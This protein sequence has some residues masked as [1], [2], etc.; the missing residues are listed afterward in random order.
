MTETGETTD[1]CLICRSPTDPYFSKSYDG[2]PGSPF[3]QGL[4]V[5]YRR[6]GQ[7]GFV[8]SQTHRALTPAQW[9]QLNASWH[10]HFESGPE[11]RIVNQPPYAD[12]ALALRLL[13]ANGLVD[14]GDALDYAAGYGTLARLLAKYFATPIAIFD[15]Y[16]QSA[17]PGLTYVAEADLRRYRLVINSAMF[18]HVLTRAA[19]DEVNALVAEDGVLM[20]HSVVCER[21]PPDPDWFYLKPIVHT[22]FH[23]NRSMEILMRQWGYAASLYAPQ[24]KSWFLFKAGHPLLASLAQRAAALNAELQTRY[25]HHKPGFVDYWKGF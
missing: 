4:K 7:C 22:A 12:Q 9:E 3:P 15:R 24:A 10:H 18:E 8:L 13:G 21:V 6:C 11:A 25:L 19:L 5:D 1:S 2:Y 17:A 23:T 16:V 14:T 20:L